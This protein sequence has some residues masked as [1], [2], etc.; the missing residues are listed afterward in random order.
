MSAARGLPRLDVVIGGAGPA[1][2]AVALSLAS[3]APELRV[4]LVD[5]PSRRANVSSESAPPQVKPLLEHLGIWDAFVTS[6]QCPSY[7]TLVAWGRPRL[8]GNEFLAHTHQVGWRLDRAAFDRMMLD[9]AAA[10]V[11]TV[12]RAKVF[13]V[14]RRDDGLSVRL[15]DGAEL[16][17]RYL[18]DATGRAAA[19][20]RLFGLRPVGADRLVGVSLRMPSRSDGTEGLITESFAEGWWYTLLRPGGDRFVVCMTDADCA[21][22]MRLNSAARFIAKAKETIHV[23]RVADLVLSDADP[24][25]HPAGCRFVDAPNSLPMVCVGD[26]ASCFD[27]LSGAGIVKALRSGIFASYAVA[28]WLRGSDGRGKKRYRALMRHEF[29]AHQIA[30]R[31]FYAEERRWPD[32]P[33]WQRRSGLPAALGPPTEEGEIGGRENS[34]Q[35]AELT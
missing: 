17:A 5:T 33:F 24:A 16:E 27:P 25:I 23:K 14:T 26:A 15:S 6:G 29:E 3:V 31:K 7:R 32:Y 21:R 19:L 1:G 10:R 9:A 13:D 30:L 4:G 22:R 35:L 2:C 11:E 8:G 34:I 28:D 12:V 18:V 20:S